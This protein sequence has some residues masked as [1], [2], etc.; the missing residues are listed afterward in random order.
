[1]D[2]Q[3]HV[4]GIDLGTTNSVVAIIESGD[5]IVIPN[6]EGQPKT[7]SVVAFMEDGQVVVGEIARRQAATQPQRTIS[8]VKRLI[9][10]L[11]EEIQTE[12]SLYPFGLGEDAEGRLTIQ[13]GE[14]AW[15]PE[16]I[17]SLILQKLKQAAEDYLGEEIRRA[18]V[19]VPAY[20]DDLQRQAT[21]EAARMAGLEVLR[22][23]NE[24]TAAAMAYG[25]GRADQNVVAV[26]DFGGGTFDFSVLEIDNKTFEVLVSTGD[27]RL[28]GDDLDGLLVDYVAEQFLASNGVDLRQDLMTLRRLKEAAEKAKCELSLM[29]ETTINLPFIAY[30]EGGE[31]LHLAQAISREIFEELI[32]PLV[33]ETLDCCGKGLRQAKLRKN[34]ISKVI[35]V[36]GS[37]RIPLVQD[38][39]E[40]FFGI[41]PF[42]GL[43]PD[44][45]VAVGAATQGAVMNGELDEVVL[46]DVTP[47]CLGIE[48]RGNRKS[49]IIEKNS[50]I[51]IKVEKTFTTTEDNQS[52]VNIHVLQGDADKASECRSI[53]KFT[54]S[55][56]ENAPAGFPR[57]RVGFF[58]NADGIVE[59][60]A[61][62]LQSGVEKKL[63]INHAYLSLDE[64]RLQQGDDSRR[65]RRRRA[66]TASATNGRGTVRRLGGLAATG[67]GG[68]EIAPR[69]ARPLTAGFNASAPLAP[70]TPPS[71]PAP[72]EEVLASRKPL[73]DSFAEV[74]TDAPRPRAVTRPPQPAA[75]PAGLAPAP[76]GEPPAPPSRPSGPGLAMKD[77]SALAAGPLPPRA[78]PPRRKMVT[79]NDE[80][81]THPLP[82]PL[83]PLPPMPEDL[84]PASEEPA[85]DS[86]QPMWSHEAFGL[87]CTI[88]PSLD[89]IVSRLIEGQSDAAA[90]ES[91]TA[92][93]NAFVAFCTSHGDEIT[94]QLLLA[95]YHI[96]LKDA[97]E[98]RLILEAVRSCKPALA[99]LVLTI[100]G[101]LCQ[102]FPNY[103]AARKDRAA[104]AIATGHYA[105]AMADLEA[106]VR[107]EEGD[108]EALDQLGRLYEHLLTERPDPTIQ[109]K[110][111]KL[112]LRRQDLD[113]AIALLQQLITLPDY[114]DRANRVLGLC[115][116]QKGMR[117]LAWQKFRTLP[118]TEEMQDI[119]Y[120]L[121][122][123]MELHE[124]LI[125]AKYALERVYES[126]IN[127][128]DVA[129]R[130]RKIEYRLQLQK[131]E[132]Y[133]GAAPH[134]PLPGEV[135]GELCRR[136][137][138][139]EE[140][141]RGSMGIVYK[142]RDLT[143]DEIVAIKVL[144]DF[145]CT[146]PQAVE[147]FKQ[148]ARSARKLTHNNIVR[149]HDM[150]DLD[151]KKIISMEFI[152]G[153]NLKTLLARHVTFSEDT[154]QAYLVQ[155][156]QGLG[157][158]H[159]FHLVHR[160]IKPANIMITDNNLVK[161]TDFGIAKL[162]TEHQT[163]SGTVI[164]GT[165]LYMA[166]E[167]IEGGRIDHRCDI[168]SLG[169]MLYEMVTGQPP[170]SEGN[171]EYQHIHRTAPEISGGISEK[172][173]TVIR[174]SIEKKPDQR[175]QTVEE[176]LSY[177]G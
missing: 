151:G 54:L 6:A 64:R 19:T 1:M 5:S 31:P 91:Y 156:C 165:P 56:I 99:E 94:L 73:A 58:I 10:R 4:I 138:V 2:K 65:K 144:N 14:R 123:D 173:R 45:I 79:E 166:P 129:E 96:Y 76:A 48:I 167:Q 67:T 29:Y 158:A 168:Y 40:D 20:F 90:C 13:V 103:I 124:E 100:Y 104:F 140:I 177:L 171:I 60:T 176:I 174:R 7:P 72:D 139:I 135:G 9:G 46:L 41:L 77:F 153:E 132:R 108:K 170:F 37:T 36:G 152:E 155:I 109:F 34:D 106:A 63:T 130:M 21:L 15:F 169:I 70:A 157:Y 47:H 128:R 122:D 145:L 22:L 154:V 93:R 85:T 116:W 161:I 25:L 88:P 18:V 33:M 11:P 57:I 49:T 74:G 26:Y 111:V 107:R 126:N 118:V 127:F 53:G 131:D 55:G 81:N 83:N 113:A 86:T 147:R 149:I 102:T 101:E 95:R 146:D 12:R 125:Q 27:S 8:S 23:L 175:F 164:M 84:T 16:E 3:G 82:R 134:S 43:N 162:L 98:A 142:A 62:D 66:S 141:N 117:Y 163:K 35:L 42:K 92:A 59:I 69:P 51:P 137:E 97:E 17:S 119:L 110:L 28:G 133:G 80:T 68:A 61:A 120:R 160:D 44:E 136:F 89:S 50:T 24:P 143:L 32:G 105:M 121:A 87:G 78:E 52:F 75:P 71:P 150:F 114:R 115:F 172:L 39:V 112:H 148:E 159:R 38:S 30:R